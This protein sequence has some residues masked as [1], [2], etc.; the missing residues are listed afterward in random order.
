MF[1]GWEM[2][3]LTMTVRHN[4]PAFPIGLQNVR[5]YHELEAAEYFADRIEMSC[6]SGTHLDGP[7]H[8][9]AKRK[10]ISQL[11]LSG[12]LVG[13]GVVVDI[14]DQVGDYD[15]YGEKELL[16][17]GVE[18]RE[19]DILFIHTGYHHYASGESEAD[20][21]KYFYKHP[22]PLM[23]FTKWVKKMRIN[24]LGIDGGSQDHPLNTGLQGRLPAID[25]EFCEKHSVKKVSDIFP[26]KHWQLMH[27]EL[28][29]HGIIHVENLGGE[30]DK[31]LNERAMIGCF[32]LKLVSESAPCRVVV[33]LKR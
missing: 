1:D 2:Y 19:G 4:T 11:P 3:D 8:F 31:V 26:R 16:K 18:I 9:K 7:L 13:P 33:W 20:E 22:G 10:T 24:Y 5:I 32:P 17:T 25:K 23:G 30:I 29:K 6:H 27:R 15:F 28:F 21:I 14:S 12:K